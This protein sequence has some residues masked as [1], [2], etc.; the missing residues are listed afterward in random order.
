MA[1]KI[2]FPNRPCPK[3][4]KPIHVRIKSH[5]CGW[6]ADAHAETPSAIIRRVVTA[7]TGKAAAAGAFTGITMADIQVVKDVVNRLGADTVK[8]LA[9][10]LGK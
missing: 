3:C 8:E 6:R 7:K 5:D 9:E 1:K 2:G 10:V 4:G